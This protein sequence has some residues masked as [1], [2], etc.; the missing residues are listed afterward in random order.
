[1]SLDFDPDYLP[2]LHY[3]TKYQT[4]KIR[5]LRGG[6]DKTSSSFYIVKTTSFPQGI[7][8]TVENLERLKTAKFSQVKIPEFKFS[9][10]GNKVQVV[11]QY[12]VGRFSD[13]RE[14][15][16]L[17]KEFVERE[18]PYTFTDMKALNFIVCKEDNEIYA[19]DLTSYKEMEYSLRKKL[20]K[21]KEYQYETKESIHRAKYRDPYPNPHTF[22]H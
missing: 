1:M 22:K 19:I 15:D 7:G 20:Y 14:K 18:D 5:E 17:Y 12:I 3:S 4:D 21:L 11:T 10:D 8:E 16:I 13:I 9:T 2:Q 6:A